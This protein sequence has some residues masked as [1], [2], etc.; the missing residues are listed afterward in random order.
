L[1]SLNSFV[2]LRRAWDILNAPVAIKEHITISQYL[3]KY[4]TIMT[5]AQAEI[6][7]GIKTKTVVVK[8][9]PR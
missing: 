1:K 8:K 5:T 9:L 6:E 4:L 3:L 7:A 2:G